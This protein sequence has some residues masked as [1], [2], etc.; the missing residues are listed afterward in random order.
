MYIKCLFVNILGDFSRLD[1]NYVPEYATI[2]AAALAIAVSIGGITNIMIRKMHFSV[3]TFSVG[4]NCSN[5]MDT[6]NQQKS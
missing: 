5:F 4:F 6:F 1:E 3:Y 2:M